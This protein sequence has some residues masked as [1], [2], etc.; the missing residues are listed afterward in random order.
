MEKRSKEKN[1]EKLYVF[2]GHK[3][4]EYIKMK[5]FKHRITS[6]LDIVEEELTSLSLGELYSKIC[7]EKPALK[8]S[9]DI[10]L[11]ESI[12]Y[13]RLANVYI[14]KFNADLSVPKFKRNMK[15]LIRELNFNDNIPSALRPAMREDGFFLMDSLNITSIKSKFIAGFD[16][17]AEDEKLIRARVLFVEVVPTGES[18]EYFIAGIDIDFN[19]STYLIMIKNKQNISK[20]E[21]EEESEDLDR[22]V[23]SLY[24]RVK[25]SIIKK[26]L[27]TTQPINVEEDRSG[28]YNLCKG[29]DEELLKDIRDEVKSRISSSLPSSVQQLVSDL[30][31]SKNK[32]KKSDLNELEEN[33]AS[34]LT[35]TYI[36]TNYKAAELL[37]RA[38]EKKLVGY[39]T[40]IKFTSNR[41]NKGSTESINS[42]QPVSASD[43]FHSLYISFRDALGLEQWSISWF[44]DYEFKDQSNYDVVQT[45]IYSRKSYFKVVFI[46]TRALD[47]E[48]IYHVVR[49][50]NKNR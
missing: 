41:A 21:N 25:N 43:M 20:L 6:E 48:L 31:P 22:T 24:D 38:K 46:A 44:T 8:N 27:F 15:K 36:K 17:E 49:Y 28:M 3:F 45:T 2:A 35:A 47:R 10:I 12:L 40:K 18:T 9:L 1:I 5:D 7:M 4:A 14:E 23:H 19:T 29:L 39:P 34:L 50:L 16:Y 33:I 32:P 13:S 42:R 26:L 37:K 30:F 11:F